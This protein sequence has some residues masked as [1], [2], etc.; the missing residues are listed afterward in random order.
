MNKTF[1]VAIGT[2]GDESWELKAEIAAETALRTSADNVIHVHGDTLAQARNEAVAE[3]G[4]D[5]VVVLDADDMLDPN[6][7]D[8]LIENLRPDEKILYQP[9]T[10]GLHM[11]GHW[12]EL[13]NIIAD[14]GM[15][16][17]NS[18]V[19]GT[20]FSSD[21]FF[22]A[23]GFEEYP[24]LEDWAL[25]LQMIVNGAK[26]LS[27]PEMV[28]VVCFMNESRNSNPVHHTTYAQIVNKFQGYRGATN[29][30]KAD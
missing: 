13:A 1:G 21:M 18:L 30:Y 7:I 19:I 8:A 23:G 9:A 25:F 20:A 12:D 17:A 5:Y 16:T 6:Y 4:T 2:F 14:R 3:L 24:V 15:F 28:Y 22:D 27:V 11:D 26:I 29:N 10:I